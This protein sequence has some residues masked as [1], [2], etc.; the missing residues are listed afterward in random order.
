MSSKT[1]ENFPF[2]KLYLGNPNGL[3]GGSYFSNIKLNNDNGVLIQMPK[4]TTKNGIHTTGKKTYT[5]LLFD[6]S[7]EK[8][9]NWIDTLTDTI[10]NLIYEKKDMWFQDDLSFDDI[11]Y[12]WQN[13]LRKYKK[14]NLL[15]RCFI[16]K[17]KNI[18]R[19]ELV[20]VYDE[21][22]NNLSLDDINSESDIIPLIQLNGLKFT[23]HNFSLEFSLKQVM[24]LKKIS[25]THL[26]KISKPA[27]SN[28][29]D[30]DDSTLSN[31]IVDNNES[32][33]NTQVSNDI[34]KLGLIN[35][36]ATVEDYVPTS[37]NDNVNNF[38]E[39][40]EDDVSND[41]LL[42]DKIA[43]EKA[44]QNLNGVKG[45]LTDSLSND[46]SNDKISND[47]KTSNILQNN[48]LSIVKENGV[49]DMKSEIKHE[50]LEEKD[51]NNLEKNEI[52]VKYN[53]GPTLETEFEEP[54]SASKLEEPESASKLE[55]KLTSETELETNLGEK[56]VLDNVIS[57]T[58]VDLNNNDSNT[59]EK[60]VINGLSE[61]ELNYPKET[62]NVMNLRHPEEVYIGIY[63]EAKRR[64]KEAKRAAIEAVLE[65][66]RIKNKYMLDEIES[67]DDEF[68][69]LEG[70]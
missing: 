26:I 48:S 14:K 31:D 42:S 36:N 17:P 5:D 59:L 33:S 1:D 20:M 34:T 27:T 46:V 52:K 70:E 67:S 4:C 69:L 44:G 24:V 43:G 12:A 39:A 51:C 38:S 15:F 22:E 64:A 50:N 40:V 21:E 13:I 30:N 18:S 10:K 16:K 54:E 61:V 49:I 47:N 41:T 25:S 57:N 3:Q 23:S 9:E 55:T 68:E 62:E 7:D 37:I 29:L 58:D 53:N 56:I 11:E 35:S 66:K 32:I 65:L 8:F 63:S 19:D 28:S 45:S 60:P 6:V 2:S